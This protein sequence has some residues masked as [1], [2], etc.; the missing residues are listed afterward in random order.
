MELYQI[1]ELFYT[2]K[3]V[4]MPDL[5]LDLQCA[6]EE[7]NYR[8]TLKKYIN[9]VLLIIDEWLLLPLSDKDT[10]HLLE[11]IHKR[12]KHSSTIFCSQFREEGWYT[13]LGGMDNPL[14]DAIVDRISYDSYKIEIESKDPERDISMREAYGLD[15]TEAK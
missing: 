4:R 12:R 13:K 2:V 8:E 5:L 6:K 10:P 15:A 14:T 3:Y 7:G 9:P 1:E 11:V